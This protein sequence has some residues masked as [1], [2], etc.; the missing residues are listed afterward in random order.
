MSAD[1]LVPSCTQ[2]IGLAAFC[3]NC[4]LFFVFFLLVSPRRE[5]DRS[6]D[7]HLCDQFRA[8]VRHGYG[9]SALPHRRQHF[10]TATMKMKKKK[11]KE[12][13]FR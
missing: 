7:Q 13:D 1:R 10:I 4:F 5:R 2:T 12:R 8:C 6:E 9:E 11:N 3:S